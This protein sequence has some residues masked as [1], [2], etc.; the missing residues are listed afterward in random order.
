MA[1]GG[2]AVGFG[3]FHGSLDEGGFAGFTV[4]DRGSRRMLRGQSLFGYNIVT[5]DGS[6]NDRCVQIDGIAAG[7]RPVCAAST[8]RGT[9]IA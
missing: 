1:E 9:M 8:R 7:D 4:R 6:E 2:E 5:I 3:R